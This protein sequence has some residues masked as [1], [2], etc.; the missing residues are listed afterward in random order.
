MLLGA[1][2]PRAATAASLL[3]SAYAAPLRH[4]AGSEE[5]AITWHSINES[6]IYMCGHIPSTIDTLYG[7]LYNDCMDGHDDS[8]FHSGIEVNT[9]FNAKK[10]AYTKRS[11]ITFYLLSCK[12]PVKEFG[13]L[14]AADPTHKRYE[15]LYDLVIRAG[16]RDEWKRWDMLYQKAF[17]VTPSYVK[18][19]KVSGRELR[20]SLEKQLLGKIEEAMSVGTAEYLKGE[21]TADTVVDGFL[22]MLRRGKCRGS[23]ISYTDLT[24]LVACALKS[25]DPKEAIQQFVKPLVD[26]ILGMYYTGATHVLNCA[27]AVRDGSEGI[28]AVEAKKLETLLF[29]WEKLSLILVRNDM[30]RYFKLAVAM[31]FDPREVTKYINEVRGA[32]PHELDRDAL[33]ALSAY[34][35]DVLDNSG[36]TRLESIIDDSDLI[37]GLPNGVV[38][39]LRQDCTDLSVH[40]RAKAEYLQE[41][42]NVEPKPKA[43]GLRLNF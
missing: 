35:M 30:V 23:T 41:R 29:D 4:A 7:E 9:E 5:P 31:D 42:L 43:L 11:F 10:D 17:K 3:L 20:L 14:L 37:K 12:E 1:I 39:R 18:E 8:K 33:N 27:L 19:S 16:S 34:Y 15:V 24:G 22:H 40:Y 38:P 32:T 26:C 2:V 25:E 6:I 36:R 13:R 28:G 21:L